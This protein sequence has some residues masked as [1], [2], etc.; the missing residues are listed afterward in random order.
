AEDIAHGT[1]Y[2]APTNNA[3]AVFVAPPTGKIYVTVNGNMN[4]SV[5]GRFAYISWE[6]REGNVVGSGTVTLAADDTRAIRAGNTVT[7]GGENV[8]QGS[9]RYLVTGLTPGDDYKI[10]LMRPNSGTV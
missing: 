4:V 10:Q 9:H 5:N 1:S 2:A 7:T 8:F 3:T 6:L